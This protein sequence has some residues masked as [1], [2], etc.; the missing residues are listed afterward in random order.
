V[1]ESANTT[2]EAR[3]RVLH[4]ALL[5]SFT[6]FFALR[7]AA[8]LVQ[9]AS[10]VGFLP[11]FDAWQGSGLDYPVLLTSEL[12]ILAGMMMW[13]T[14]AVSRG[15]LPRRRA[16]LWLVGLGGVYFS[17]MCARLVLGLTILAD[18]SWFA[19]PLPALFHLVLASYLL[20]LGRYHFRRDDDA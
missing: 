10:P 9:Y 16:G 17:S 15:M 8:Q 4:A 2:G 12:V 7:V 14:V 20:C 5:L 18:V 1:T 13:G 6:T 11:P 19:K 3:R